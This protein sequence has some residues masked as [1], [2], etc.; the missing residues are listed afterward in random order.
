MEWFIGKGRRKDKDSPTP[1]I[2]DE[3]KQYLEES[4]LRQRVIDADFHQ[5][6]KLPSNL[7][8]NEWLAT[9]TISFFNHVNLMYGVVSEYCT[10]E[11]CSSMVGPDNVQ[12]H[13]QD[14]KGKKVKQTAPQYIDNMMSYIQK[15][16]TDESVF[17]TKFGQDFPSCFC[18][19][20]R[21]IHRYLFHVLAHL[22]HS[23]YGLLAQLG[24]QGHLNTLF[25]H[26]MV[27]STHFHLI[28]EKETDV[29]QDLHK[30]LLRAMQDPNEN[31]EKVRSN[32]GDGDVP[33]TQSG[34]GSSQEIDSAG[35][36]SDK[37]RSP[38][39]FRSK[40]GSENGSVAREDAL[41]QKGR[42]LVDIPPT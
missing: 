20:I 7:D 41:G 34:R 19:T 30:G 27:F 40:S 39:E 38:T 25:M 29:L 21:K 8:T 14:E 15:S 1:P 17:P 12:Y 22:Y 31:S 37:S 28:D 23:H 9:H 32:E 24:L 42:V 3:Q 5:L 13:S 11:T 4:C 6:V 33:Q 26:F 18:D 36:L 35:V 10:P 16:V 2:S